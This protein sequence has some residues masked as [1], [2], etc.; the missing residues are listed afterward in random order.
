MAIGVRAR[1]WL[2]AVV[3]VLTLTGLALVSLP[4]PASAPGGQ[5][6]QGQPMGAVPPP[7]QPVGAADA[8]RADAIVKLLDRRASAMV[9][10]D[11]A[12]FLATLDPQ[13]DPAF[14][15]AQLDLFANLATVP[16][17]AWSYTVRA[18]DTIDL[19]TLP[20]PAA[21]PTAAELW[22]PAVD[23]SYALR[24]V[25]QVP[26]TRAMGY[27]FVR[28]AGGWFLRSDTALN[29]LGR[30]S[31][32]GP[33]DF[34]PCEVTSTANGIVLAHPGSKPMVDRL[35]RELDSSVR[36][37]TEVWGQ[38][39]PQRVALILP[40]SPTEMRSLVGPDFPVE[41]VVAVAIADR[42]DT[43]KGTATGQR[44]VLS[45]AGSRALSVSSLR[46]VLRHEI[47]HVAARVA[48][49]D[50]SPMWLLEGFADYVGYRD[51]GIG[52][53][54]GAP[55]LARKVRESGPPTALP[56][57][58]EFRARDRSLDLA[59]QQAWSLSRFI[60]DRLGEPR[61]VALYRDL[62]GAGPLSAAD[63]DDLLR[64]AI[65]MDRAVLLRE[66]QIYLRAAF[67]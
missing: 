61:L 52:L 17:D 10:R 26:T 54:Q 42:V 22:A 49:V 14:L 16:L 41:A 21:D 20:A 63:T 34:G 43:A 39:W 47:T 15:Q 8:E 27:L 53:V 11:E 32:R 46:V 30:R 36:A 13:A 5:S 9:R 44:V 3:A 12:A 31:W 64:R 33:W 1:T 51:S 19:T 28:R 7:S 59:Y 35:V 45:P 60:A 50:G 58:R 24:G 4:D 29:D 40:D 57:D 2:S 65:G 18:D 37:V 55:D 62:A 25:D 23:L 38:A 66:W 48:T 56:E 67:R 6:G